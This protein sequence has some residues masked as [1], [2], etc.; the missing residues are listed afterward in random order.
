MRRPL[1]EQAPITSEDTK[2]FKTIRSFFAAAWTDDSGLRDL[3][4]HRLRDIGL[5]G[6]DVVESRRFGGAARTNF[7]NQRRQERANTWLM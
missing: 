5:S 6:L 1:P 7:L 2:M 4:S 3:D